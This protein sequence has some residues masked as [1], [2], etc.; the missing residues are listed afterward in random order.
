M[1][2]L[3]SLVLRQRCAT[4]SEKPSER[5]DDLDDNLDEMHTTVEELED[6]PPKGVEPHTLKKLKD[7][8]ETAREAADDVEDEQD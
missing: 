6:D 5:I 4:V 8:L 1:C 7:A 3:L 2:S